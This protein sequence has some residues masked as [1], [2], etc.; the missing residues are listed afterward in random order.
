MMIIFDK[1]K[2]L[3]QNLGYDNNKIPFIPL[4]EWLEDCWIGSKIFPNPKEAMQECTRDLIIGLRDN[5]PDEPY[6]MA[7]S[8]IIKKL[9]KII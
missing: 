6:K 2:I 1:N 5:L 7:I 3:I 8:I 4:E 9:Q